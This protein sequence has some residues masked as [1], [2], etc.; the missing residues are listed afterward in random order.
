MTILIPNHAHRLF[1]CLTEVKH[2]STFDLTIIHPKD[3][4][5]IA[6]TTLESIS[7]IGSMSISKFERTPHIQA[8]HLFFAIWTYEPRQLEFMTVWRPPQM[9]PDLLNTL[10]KYSLKSNKWMMNVTD[11]FYSVDPMNVVPFPSSRIADIYVT[12]GVSLFR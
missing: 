2:T 12:L 9:N 3:Y 7:K 10:T 6:G 11:T 4:K 5:L 8:H 1:P